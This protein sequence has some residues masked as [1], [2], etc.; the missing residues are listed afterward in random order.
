MRRLPKFLRI[1]ALRTIVT[2]EENLHVDGDDPHDV[3]PVR[4]YGVFDPA[5]PIITLDSANGSERMKHTLVH[6]S[7]HAMLS[8]AHVLMDPDDEEAMVGRLTPVLLGFLR[9]NVGAVLYLQES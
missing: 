7:L 9:S 4:A 1:G 8:S 3:G 2:V 6:E 5:I